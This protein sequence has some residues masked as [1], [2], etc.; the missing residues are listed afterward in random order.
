MRL[1]QRQGHG[2]RRSLAGLAPRLDGSAVT[3]RYSATNCQSDSGSFVL[4]SAVEALEHRENAL[5]V[6]LVEA[7]A[8]VVDRDAAAAV[9]DGGVDAHQRR[10]SGTMELQ[11]VAGE[12]LQQ[13]PHLQRVGVDR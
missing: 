7:D 9:A 3:F 1:P 13:L 11:R 12:V 4:A 5:R 2:E 10:H 8:V 6:L